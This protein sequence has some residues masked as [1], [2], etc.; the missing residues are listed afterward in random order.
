MLREARFSPVFSKVCALIHVLL[1]P[2]GYLKIDSARSRVSSK[3][4]DFMG[5]AARGINFSFGVSS[6]TPTS[7][8]EGCRGKNAHY[9]SHLRRRR[10]QGSSMSHEAY[11]PEK[12]TGK[13]IKRVKILWSARLCSAQPIQD[14][15][16]SLMDRTFDRNVAGRRQRQ[17]FGA[18]RK[19]PMPLHFLRELREIYGSLSPSVLVKDPPYS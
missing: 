4:V 10:R 12:G 7:E 14:D 16:R 1:Y 8:W 18:R 3:P 17:P 19:Y 13:I 15:T 11:S 2:C 5:K 9:G 6:A